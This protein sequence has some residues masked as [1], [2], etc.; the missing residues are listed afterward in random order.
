[1][2]WPEPIVASSTHVVSTLDERSRCLRPP[3]LPMRYFALIALLVGTLACRSAPHAPGGPAALRVELQA[4]VGAEE[5]GILGWNG[6]LTFE[7]S[8]GLLAAPATVFVSEIDE[9]RDLSS[10]LANEW[11]TAALPTCASLE[12]EVP[13]SG[14][15]SSSG[16]PD[17]RLVVAVESG[18]TSYWAEI[19][20]PRR[21]LTTSTASGSFQPV[22]VARWGE[23]RIFQPDIGGKI[24]FGEYDSDVNVAPNPESYYLKLDRQRQMNLT[25][26]PTHPKPE[27]VWVFCLLQDP[28]PWIDRPPAIALIH[29]QS[30]DTSLDRF[31]VIDL[32][33]GDSVRIAPGGTA[34]LYVVIRDQKGDHWHRK[35]RFDQVGVWGGLYRS[36]FP[37]W[38][39]DA[40]ATPPI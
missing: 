14:T 22:D 11:R 7:G 1:M 8:N 33:N 39:D 13:A 5:E 26:L 28:A 2:T 10:V 32:K 21:A 6:T 23:L 31:P 25:Y 27:Y 17:V 18:G 38:R 15:F 9:K 30:F 29:Q 3:G 19:T 36:L 35:Q 4:S 16:D 34:W 12:G 40:I 24:G 20:I 37:Q